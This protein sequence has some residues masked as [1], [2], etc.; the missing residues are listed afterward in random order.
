MIRK[1]LYAAAF[2]FCFQLHLYP[3]DLVKVNVI[4]DAQGQCMIISSN[5]LSYTSPIVF[6]LYNFS[7]FGSFPEN[8]IELSIEADGVDWNGKY[9]KLIFPYENDRCVERRGINN[10]ILNDGCWNSEVIVVFDTEQI[11]SIKVCNLSNN[12]GQI[13]YKVSPIL[14]MNN[15][16]EQSIDTIVCAG[17]INLLVDDS[18][19]ILSKN[20]PISKSIYDLSNLRLGERKYE[21]HLM[22]DAMLMNN[23]RNKNIDFVATDWGALF[24]EAS[25][26]ENA[27]S[28]LLTDNFPNISNK[29]SEMNSIIALGNMLGDI[30]EI[31]NRV[32]VIVQLDKEF[33]DNSFN[34]QRQMFFD[35]YLAKYLNVTITEDY[36]IDLN[37]IYDLPDCSSFNIFYELSLYPNPTNDF[38]KVDFF[39]NSRSSTKYKLIIFNALGKKV[40]EVKEF[41]GENYCEAVLNISYYS[42]GIYFLV[43]TDGL[44]RIVRTEG[45]S[46]IN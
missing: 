46:I 36:N 42:P 2:S 31:S 44:N 28:V 30:K 5:E 41:C 23:N 24:K 38:L 6:S 45:F 34:E 26:N 14:K 4:E 32:K 27:L 40:A 3:Q 18:E 13:T 39:T 43:L 21:K 12:F 1:I 11:S 20:N 22:S 10:F 17:E 19:S 15:K 9:P 33:S 8:G 25:K 37:T 7:Y 29:Q 16:D 35:E